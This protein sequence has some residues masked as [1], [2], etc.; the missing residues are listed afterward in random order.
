MH[1]IIIAALL[2]LQTWTP[3]VYQAVNKYEIQ[4]VSYSY[5]ADVAGWAL[6]GQGIIV[7]VETHLYNAT[8]VAGALAHETKHLD[9]GCPIYRRGG[10]EGYYEAAAYAYQ[11]QTWQR[12]VEAEVVLAAPYLHTWLPLYWQFYWLEHP[13]GTRSLGVLPYRSMRN[14]VVGNISQVSMDYFPNI[15][16]N[17]EGSVCTCWLTGSWSEQ[18][19]WMV[20]L[21]T[22]G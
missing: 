16:Q 17:N 8:L 6:C 22:P 4:T 9:D 3:D 7:L 14:E 11:L 13:P 18:R 20:A 12:L 10:R 2:L 1:P 5:G 15:S 19:R 21:S